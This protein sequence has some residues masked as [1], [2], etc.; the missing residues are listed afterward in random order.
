MVKH[1]RLLLSFPVAEGDCTHVDVEVF[2]DKGGMNYFTG[3]L[4]DR[5]YY[6]SAQPLSKDKNSYCYTA[7]SGV[8]QLIQPA[9]RFSPKTLAEIVIDYDTLDSMVEHVLEKN[10]L[11]LIAFPD[12]NRYNISLVTDK[13]VE[14]KGNCSV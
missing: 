5:G 10:K 8:K 1:K 11:K 6:L 7:F 9:G 3:K 13:S 14:A 2:Y 4:E 12:K